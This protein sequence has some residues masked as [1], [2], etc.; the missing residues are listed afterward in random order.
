LNSCRKHDAL[1]ALDG[2]IYDPSDNA[3]LLNMR[4]VATLG[5]HENLNRREHLQ[6]GRIAK[7]TRG[8]AVSPPPRGFV[9]QADGTWTKDP[10]PSVRAALDPTGNLPI[11]QRAH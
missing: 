8:Q 3:N 6:H 9:A 10:D 1:L 11:L 2:K 7:V 5:E 4:L